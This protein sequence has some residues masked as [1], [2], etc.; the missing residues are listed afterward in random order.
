MKYIL[1][2]ILISSNNDTSLTMQEFDTLDACEV[3]RSRVIDV[4]RTTPD[5]N[6]GT[7]GTRTFCLKK[8]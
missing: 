4:I 3:A 7:Y 2:I 8:G 1:F 6:I 5:Y